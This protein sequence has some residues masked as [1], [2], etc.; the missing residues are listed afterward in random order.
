MSLRRQTLL[1]AIA[2]S[3]GFLWVFVAAAT[4]ASAVIMWLGVGV[5]VVGAAWAVR[6]RIRT[7]L[8]GDQELA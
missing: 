8:S 4:S 7:M 6:T 2:T 5:L 1:S 3:G